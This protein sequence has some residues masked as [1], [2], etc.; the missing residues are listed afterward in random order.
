MEF[1]ELMLYG[2]TVNL[3]DDYISSCRIRKEFYLIAQEGV[4]KFSKIYDQYN[5][6]GD[7][8][9]YMPI[10]VENFYV[11]IAE[12]SVVLLR[13]YG[14]Y[15]EN[16]ESFLKKSSQYIGEFE[17]AHSI[18]SEKYFQLTNQ[19]EEEKQYRAYKKEARTRLVGGGFGV[20]G[21]IKGM[22]VAGSVNLATGIVHS[23]FNSIDGA[24]TNSQINRE[25][26]KIYKEEENKHSILQGIFSD[27]N[28]FVAT[29]FDIVNY[30]SK[31]KLLYKPN[32]LFEAKNI[33]RAVNEGV[34]P[35]SEINKAIVQALKLAPYASEIYYWAYNQ[36]G[37]EKGELQSFA[38][39]FGVNGDFKGMQED[40]NKAIEFFGED[41]ETIKRLYQDSDM[42]ELLKHTLGEPLEKV[43]TTMYLILKGEN[44]D[45]VRNL[46]F[47]YAP[48]FEEQKL[49]NARQS[50]ALLGDNEKALFLFDNTIWGNGKEGFVLTDQNLYYNGGIIDL[51]CVET[52]EYDWGIKINGIKIPTGTYSKSES[53]AVIEM[54]ELF[55]LIR[56][57]MPEERSFNYQDGHEEQAS[58]ALRISSEEEAID[59]MGRM[60]EGI[61][62]SNFYR[63]VYPISNQ[64]KSKKKITNASLAYKIS[65]E[66][67]PLLC[68]DNTVF[69]SAKDGCLVTT[70][71]I[72]VHNPF[73]DVQKFFFDEIECIEIKGSFS[74]DL[75]VNG[76]E[77][78]TSVLSGDEKKLFCSVLN[79]II[80]DLK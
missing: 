16:S 52:I 33:C 41:Y 55:C 37:D 47:T 70:K 11:E 77:V 62:N 4:E 48:G 32:Q 54:L 69:G 35:E 12:R 38:E 25:L 22:A 17:E 7:V 29:F 72:Y 78:K 30:H 34:V 61:G 23:I 46:Y 31:C 57:H 39:L 28:F 8:V 44:E 10:A 27:I 60:L 75:Y 45:F 15:T 43:A 66:E 9:S 19:K 50:Y 42:Y 65:L 18:L 63:N 26:K 2:E 68:L 36:L 14:I 13:N 20:S 3:S 53:E 59:Y 1:M 6:L 24:I 21:A 58:T 80:R 40:E 76:N 56:E 64:E 67:I 73:E 79:G 5:S 51:D 71:G 74:K 49:L